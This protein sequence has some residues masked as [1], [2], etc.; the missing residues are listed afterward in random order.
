MEPLKAQRG[1]RI[2]ASIGR[3]LDRSALHFAERDADVLV[4]VR[5]EI[6]EAALLG[7]KVFQRESHHV[8]RGTQVVGVHGRRVGGDESVRHVDVI[9]E[10]AADLSRSSRQ[11]VPHSA[12]R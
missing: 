2:R 3:I 12:I 4:E 9:F 1:H 10:K 7:P 8:F 6:D 11:S 5:G